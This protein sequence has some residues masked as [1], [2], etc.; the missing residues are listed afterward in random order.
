MRVRIPPGPFELFRAR[1]SMAEHENV[2][3]VTRTHRRIDPPDSAR[4]R[5]QK[6]TNTCRFESYIRRKRV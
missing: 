1:S 2:A 5:R 4:T 3:H 6:H